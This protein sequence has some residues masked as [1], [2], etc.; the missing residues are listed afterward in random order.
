M[1]IQPPEIDFPAADFL[2]AY[3]YLKNIDNTEN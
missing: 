3:D 2:S 1:Q